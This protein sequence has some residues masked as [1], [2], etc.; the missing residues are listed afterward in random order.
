MEL[1]V[2]EFCQGT[3]ELRHEFR[4]MVGCDMI[5]DTVFGEDVDEE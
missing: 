5:R 4:T 3:H 2:K 1:Q